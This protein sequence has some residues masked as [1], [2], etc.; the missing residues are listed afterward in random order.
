MV[1][2]SQT[3]EAWVKDA[4]TTSQAR[5][6]PFKKTIEDDLSVFIAIVRFKFVFCSRI[7]YLVETVENKCDI[8]GLTT[9]LR[10]KNWHR[11]DLLHW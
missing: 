3:V 2:P 7:F 1:G 8:K 5:A 11:L 6:A 4:A 10:D 9:G